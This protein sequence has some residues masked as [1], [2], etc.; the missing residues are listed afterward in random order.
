MF[1]RILVCLD[2]SDVAEQILPYAAGIG[3]A[4]HS[5]LLVLRVISTNIKIPAGDIGYLLPPVGATEPGYDAA[6]Q[7]AR[8]HTRTELIDMELEDNEAR[9]YLEQTVEYLLCKG[10][11]VETATI[12]GK[13]GRAIVSY[14]K[15]NQVDLIA[16]ASRSR[17]GLGRTVFGSTADSVLHESGLPILMIKP[18][19]QTQSPFNGKEEHIFG[20][21]LVCLD[22][23]DLAELILP[24]ATEQARR[25]GSELVL[26]QVVPSARTVAAAGSGASSPTTETD[27]EE[28]GKVESKA[29][30]YL[31]NVAQ[32]LQQTG[33]NVQWLILKGTAGDVIVS[34]AVSND[35]D[36]IAIAT[37]GR[38]GLKRTVFGSVADY[39]L[40]ESGLPIL[41]IKPQ[42]VKT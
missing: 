13:P 2:G 36:L 31:A 37:H 16:L 19:D 11:D 30:T 27:S 32:S 22:G 15:N 29:K 20:K 34:C 18:K 42:E 12:Q 17:T 33:L 28:T 23:S 39:V 1:E 4:F 35:I 9:S 6:L 5:K 25:F 14:A 10:L 40:R 26:L 3:S 41:L 21:I 24:Y 38:S 8:S 7:A